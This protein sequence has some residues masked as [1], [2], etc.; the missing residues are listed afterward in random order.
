MIILGIDPGVAITGFA[1][2]NYVNN[3]YEPVIWGAIRTPASEPLG[4]RLETIYA[5]MTHILTQYS[6]THMAIESLFFNTNTRTAFLV[7]QARGVILLAASQAGVTMHD[8]T[9]LQVKQAVTGYGNATK[10][11][12]QYMVTHLLG[13]NATPKPDDVADALAVAICGINRGDR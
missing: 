2:I 7:G 10:Q 4:M 12:V 9:P 6:P 3:R 13:L 11:Q 8:Y 5:D 1:I